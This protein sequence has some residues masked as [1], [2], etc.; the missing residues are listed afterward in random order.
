MCG[1]RG[2]AVIR[3]RADGPASGE[4]MRFVRAGEHRLRIR[5]EAGAGT[6]TPV[7]RNLRVRSVPEM[8]YCTVPATAHSGYGDVLHCV[9]ASARTHIATGST[10]HAYDVTH[11]GVLTIDATTRTVIANTLVPVG[12][13]TPLSTPYTTG[14]VNEGLMSH[15]PERTVAKVVRLDN[16]TYV[17]QFLIRGFIAHLQWTDASPNAPT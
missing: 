2:D 16:G 7:V 15:G 9:Y 4:A 8:M 3:L 5:C 6:A 13:I 11:L 17:T 1:D 12:A 10:E 14:F